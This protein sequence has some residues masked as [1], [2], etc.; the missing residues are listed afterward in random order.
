MLFDGKSKDD[1][2]AGFCK[3]KK[4]FQRFKAMRLRTTRKTLHVE[5]AHDYNVWL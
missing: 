5:L 1:G 4:A 3:D 2:D